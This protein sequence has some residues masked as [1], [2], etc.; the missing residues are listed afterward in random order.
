LYLEGEIILLYSFFALISRMKNISRWSL[1]RNN[2][3][4]NV[5]EHSHQVAVIA[6][7]LAV[8][9]RDV[10]GKDSDPG[11]VAVAALFHDASE[12][13]TGDMPT[14]I[15]YFSPDIMAAYKRVESLAANKLISTLPPEMRQSYMPLL[16]IVDDDVRPL[17]KAADALAA[18]IKCLEEL[19]AGNLEFRLA[20]KQTRKKLASFQMPEVEFF[21]ENFIP[22]FKLTLDEL[23]LNLE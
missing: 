12:I 10:Y 17:V 18:Y 14:P 6:H 4:E 19:K 23:D 5:Q 3:Y 8:I 16:S 15:K 13:L 11:K 22:A 1:M 20:A 2:E 7:G 21:M 9:R